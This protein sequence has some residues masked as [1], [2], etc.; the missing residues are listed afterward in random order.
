M[1]LGDPW[2]SIAE[3]FPNA[4]TTALTSRLAS[5]FISSGPFGRVPD[6]AASITASIIGLAIYLAIML[7]AMLFVVQRRDVTV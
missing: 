1:A 3:H 4:Y 5:E 6:N 2:K 7:G